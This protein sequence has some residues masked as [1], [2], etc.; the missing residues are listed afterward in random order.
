M[1]ERNQ[2]HRLHRSMLSPRHGVCQTRHLILARVDGCSEAACIQLHAL[3]LDNLAHVRRLWY[4]TPL[5]SNGLLY[6][7]Y[8]P[9]PTC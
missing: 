9:H 4:G 6:P 2:I 5:Q 1:C 8:R 3:S 7:A